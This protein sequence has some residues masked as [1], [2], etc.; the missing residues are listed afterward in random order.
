MDYSELYRAANRNL[1]ALADGTIRR[2][3]AAEKKKLT[4][5]Q[6]L[7]QEKKQLK[8][9]LKKAQA[10]LLQHQRDWDFLYKLDDLTGRVADMGVDDWVV[11]EEVDYQR[12]QLVERVCRLRDELI[13]L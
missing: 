4:L 2:Q 12:E 13:W 1:V 10:E 11:M 8:L 5:A 6:E 3:L 7:A 9:E